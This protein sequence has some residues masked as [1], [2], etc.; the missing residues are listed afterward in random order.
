MSRRRASPANGASL[1]K[2][3]LKSRVLS[4]SVS[5]LKNYHHVFFPE[6]GRS[7]VFR[8]LGVKK[9]PMAATIWGARKRREFVMVTMIG[10]NKRECTLLWYKFRWLENDE[11]NIAEILAKRFIA[12]T[13]FRSSVRNR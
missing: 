8:L 6:P 13:F 4:D 9:N 2:R 5:D 3:R 7:T 1:L 10:L 11:P 12:I